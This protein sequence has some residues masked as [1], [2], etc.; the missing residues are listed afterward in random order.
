[1]VPIINALGAAKK[2]SHGHLWKGMEAQ[3]FDG[4]TW[5][6]L[7]DVRLFFSGPFIFQVVEF[8]RSFLGV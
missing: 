3:K 1:M 7:D 5:H 2:N 4:L 6:A 8:G